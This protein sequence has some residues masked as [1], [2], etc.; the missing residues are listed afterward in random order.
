MPV[1][2]SQV[3]PCEESIST[4]MHILDYM[5]DKTRYIPSMKIQCYVPHSHEAMDAG[6]YALC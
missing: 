4:Y 6:A 5:S 2:M 1:C 3:G